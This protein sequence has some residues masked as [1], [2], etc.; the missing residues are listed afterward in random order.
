MRRDEL[1]SVDDFSDSNSPPAF[2][3]L[4][5][6]TVYE[7]ASESETNTENEKLCPGSMRAETGFASSS[8]AREETTSG[9]GRY[10]RKRSA[11]LLLFSCVS[12][13]TEGTY[14]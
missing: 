14:Y 2:I 12:P 8:P 6:G 3:K 4:P 1:S 10:P 13:K 7:I 11:K 9:T 5:S